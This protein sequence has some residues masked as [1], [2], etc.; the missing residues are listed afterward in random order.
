MST[1][2]VIKEIDH[3]ILKLNRPEKH[4]AFNVEMITELT[5]FFLQ[6]P[7]D[8][9]AR[10]IVMMGAGP[11]FC[12]GADID[13]MKS[14]AEF[15]FEQNRKDAER[16][17]EMFEAADN[18]ALPVIGY[19]QGSI[20]G[21]GVGLVSICDIAVAEA[22]AKFCF[23]E[24]RLGLIPG[25]IS[26]FVMRKMRP[27]KARE[28]M[29]TAA[30]FSA[31]QAYEAGLIEHFER[32]LEAREYLTHALQSITHNGPEALREIKNLLRYGRSANPAQMKVE[33]V[34]QIAERRVSSEGQEG[35]ASFLQ[36]RKPGWIR[37]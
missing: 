35:L 23:S 15:S 30:P 28:F 3:Y 32:E 20:F 2:E 12:S 22:N 29:L 5:E 9:F 21:G 13:W 31:Q 19:L 36:K 6:A 10:A 18:C 7:N 34:R 11:S 24:A 4:N 1:I 33:S 27:N 25:V 16:L 37:Q 17:Y 14:M 8:K 26:S